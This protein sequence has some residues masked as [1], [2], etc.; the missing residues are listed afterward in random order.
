VSSSIFPRQLF[1][2]PYREKLEPLNRVSDK[3]AY[4]MF[5]QLT[6][7]T[8]DCLEARKSLVDLEELPWDELGL[9]APTVEVGELMGRSGLHAQR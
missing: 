5:I 3:L 2:A 9:V 7:K 8:Q 6:R 4:V 1:G